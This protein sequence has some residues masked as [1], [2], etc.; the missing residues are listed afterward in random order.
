MISI[1]ILTK[2]PGSRIQEVL[3]SVFKQNI[4][5]AFEVVIIDSGTTDGSLDIIQRFDVR[6]ATIKPADFGHGRTRNY[7]VTL[8]RGEYIVMLVQDAVPADENWLFELIKPLRGNN[9]M[10]GVY[11]RH[12]PYTN[13]KIMEKS[14]ISFKYPDT[15]NT[16]KKK[17]NPTIKDV[18]FSNVSSAMR[19]DLLTRFKFNENLIMSEDQQWAKE[20]IEN[21]YNIV[22]NPKSIVNHSHNYSLRTVFRRFFDSGVS[23]KN[24]GLISSGSYRDG[25]NYLFYEMRY[26]IR[27][28]GAV[29]FFLYLPYLAMYE[30]MRTSGFV[31]G[32]NYEMLPR[33]LLKKF[34]FHRYYWD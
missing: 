29:K 20:V 4:D 25:L 18:F 14:F 17:D 5:D 8:S 27:A 33:F 10:A 30:F 3:A 13:A 9:N 19:K 11:S 2:N 1:I 21:G 12:V 16:R 15:A 32:Q 22:Y 26:C 34:S 24:L 31:L 23:L 28:M 7:A 6:L